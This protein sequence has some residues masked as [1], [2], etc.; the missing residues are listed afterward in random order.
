MSNTTTTNLDALIE[1]E[2]RRGSERIAGLK[3]VAAAEQRRIDAKVINLLRDQDPDLYDQLTG[4]ARD[5]LAAEKARRSSRAK[6]VVAGS[7]TVV[8]GTATREVETDSEETPWN[9]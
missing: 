7:T 2:R 6:K 9:G 1:Q 4:E 8:A 3:R 5:A